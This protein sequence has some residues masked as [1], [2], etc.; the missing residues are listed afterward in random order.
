LRYHE[1]AIRVEGINHTKFGTI[2]FIENLTA[3]QFLKYRLDKNIEFTFVE[4]EDD[5]QGI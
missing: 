1:P 5:D 2:Y 3:G 4:G